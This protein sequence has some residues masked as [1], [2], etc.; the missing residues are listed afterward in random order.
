MTTRPVS[1][2]GATEVEA[3][4]DLHL[5]HNGRRSFVL[6]E[7]GLLSL[8]LLN[9]HPAAS[10]EGHHEALD[11]N[12]GDVFIVVQAYAREHLVGSDHIH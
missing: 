6:I 4:P 12:H 9:L 7:L 1:S 5:G 10:V 2:V 8:L 11:V 3:K